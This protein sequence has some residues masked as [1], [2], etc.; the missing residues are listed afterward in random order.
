MKKSIFSGSL[1]GKKAVLFLVLLVVL[2]GFACAFDCDAYSCVV[3]DYNW[4]DFSNPANN[5]TASNGQ[6]VKELGWEAVAGTPVYSDAYYDTSPL[7]I[8]NSPGNMAKH[9]FSGSFN[10][11]CVDIFYTE[12]STVSQDQY[13]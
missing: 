5:G 7:A 9:I 10:A 11:S 3:T 2:G 1:L 8:N 4:A 12:L 13:A 6:N